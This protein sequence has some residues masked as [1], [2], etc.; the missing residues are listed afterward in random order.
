MR[1]TLIISSLKAGGAERV[2]SNMASWW[3]ERGQI[4]TLITFST[5]ESDFYRLDR[6]VE[7]VA[8]NLESDSNSIF[9]AVLGNIHR[10]LVLR[11]AIRD[12]KP[13]VVISFV[14]KMNVL[15]LAAARRLGAS[16]IISERTVPSAYNIGKVWS[17]SR[18]MMYPYARWVVVQSEEVRKWVERNIPLCAQK[19]V[20]IPNPVRS[21]DLMIGEVPKRQLHDIIG[22]GDFC[23]VAVAMGRLCHEK[24]FDLLLRA[25]SE[26]S[27]TYDN[28][29]L[30]IIG[31]GEELGKLVRL[32]AELEITSKVFFTG[33]LDNPA[34]LLRQA[35]MFILSSRF[36]G[37]PNALLEA[38]ACG[39]PVISFSCPG[40]VREIV[41]DGVDGILV[42]PEDW[43]K[44]SVAI[45]RLMGDDTLRSGLSM[46]A[47]EVIER[48]SMTNVMSK[49]DNLLRSVYDRNG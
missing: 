6:R 34:M 33:R 13:D 15:V 17:K 2:I 4:V 1:I 44:L 14:E 43:H 26:V 12:S 10:I 16:V 21:E 46:R 38:M 29:R 45:K 42:F 7:R 8:V 22:K 19:T 49:W 40:G 28:W 27:I 47:T 18:R 11:K 32:A 36:E 37:F 3:A 48:F 5:N 25:F 24:G 30:V 35:D 23:R 41:R 9:G 31:E 39:L 20:I